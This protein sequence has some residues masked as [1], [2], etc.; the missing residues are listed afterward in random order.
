MLES[1]PEPLLLFPPP[2]TDAWKSPDA[3]L[4]A[5]QLYAIDEART[6]VAGLVTKLASHLDDPPSRG[7]AD[8]T[9]FSISVHEFEQLIDVTG[10]GGFY[11][12]A[13]SLTTPECSLPV[14][15]VVMARILG[16]SRSSLNAFRNASARIE[17][18][19]YR[20]APSFRPL[21]L[22]QDRDIF[23]RGAQSLACPSE[24]TSAREAAFY[25]PKDSVPIVRQVN[26]TLSEVEII[27][28]PVCT[29]TCVGMGLA[30]AFCVMAAA[31]LCWRIKCLHAQCSHLTP[32]LPT[33]PDH[34]AFH[35]SSRMVWPDL[36]DPKASAS[37]EQSLE[38]GEH[39][40][41]ASAP[42][43]S[44]AACPSGDGQSMPSSARLRG[45]CVD[46]TSPVA[47]VVPGLEV[48]CLHDPLCIH[49][50]NHDSGFPR[51]P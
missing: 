48:R 22:R 26:V 9:E 12:Y 42:I 25:C 41:S 8:V 32:K 40:C 34:K 49:C 20:S 28:K 39:G 47:L 11:A 33:S 6:E 3:V 38:A 24:A 23:H 46:D 18:N 21:Q 13:G 31:A 17:K 10:N 1:D 44:W 7:N 5:A 2:F 27:E 14:T 30:L 29:G 36:S 50:S 15:W 35:A 51:P 37:L 4:V 16:L 19:F 43:S 45:L